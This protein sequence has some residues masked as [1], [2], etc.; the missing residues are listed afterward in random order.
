MARA[1]VAAEGSRGCRGTVASFELALDIRGIEAARGENDVAVEPEVGELRH[2]ALVVLSD[3]RERGFDAFLAE[4]LR[5]RAYA[6]VEERRDVRAVGAHRGALGDHAPEPRREARLR[7]GVARGAGGPHSQQDRVA[8][9]VL[10]QLLERERVP[11]RPALVPVVLP[12]ARPEPRLAGLARQAQ[13]LVV[14]PREHQDA[15]GLR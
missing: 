1:A 11:G 7:A 6:A 3:R 9:A 10:A 13:R 14:H 15:V 2:E 12:R 4:L 5:A 8:V